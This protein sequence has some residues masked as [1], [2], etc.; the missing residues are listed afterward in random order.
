MLVSNIQDDNYYD[1]TYP[2]YIAG[3]FWTTFEQAFDRNII[4]IDFADSEEV[5]NWFNKFNNSVEEVAEISDLSM[6][7]NLFT[8]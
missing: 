4:S 2:Y 5:S 7:V 3:F 8:P 1:P 6:F